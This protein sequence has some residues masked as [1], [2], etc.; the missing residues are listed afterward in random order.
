METE[1]RSL[2]YHDDMILK[3][4]SNLNIMIFFVTKSINEG[5]GVLSSEFNYSLSDN[6][7]PCIEHLCLNRHRMTVIMTR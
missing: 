4:F 5:S 3:M 7:L 1:E 6:A 2:N